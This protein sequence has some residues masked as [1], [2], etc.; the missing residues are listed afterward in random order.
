MGIRSRNPQVLQNAL[1]AE[2]DMT[3]QTSFDADGQTDQIQSRIQQLQSQGLAGLYITQGEAIANATDLDLPLPPP[4]EDDSSSM[5]GGAIAGLVIG[6]LACI[7]LGVGGGLFA[8]K[9][10]AKS[11]GGQLDDG[12]WQQ[13]MQA[14]VTS[15]DVG[16]DAYKEM[17]GAT[18]A[19][20]LGPSTTESPRNQDTGAG[21][22]KVEL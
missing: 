14:G 19:P 22:P 1:V 15:N 17:G 21:E 8:M 18:G 12:N 4:E 6:I 2:V 11:F 10:K 5:S 13:F 3:E 7:G 20:G 16:G 9:K